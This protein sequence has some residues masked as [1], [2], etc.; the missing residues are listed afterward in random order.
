M[1]KPAHHR[2]LTLSACIAL[3]SSLPSMSWAVDADAAQAQLRSSGCLK[4]HAVDK[5]KEG[6]AYKDV[7]AKYKGKADAEQ[8]LYTRVSTVTKI[9]VDGKEEDHAMLK[10]TNEAE[11]KNVVQWILSR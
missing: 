6:P 2:A 8:M 3:L 9:K 1:S 10:T 5:A 7:A 4:C 11:I